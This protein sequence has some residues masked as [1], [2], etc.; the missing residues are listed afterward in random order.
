V[1]T[2]PGPVPC[3]QGALVNGVL[4]PIA[5]PL[6]NP[7]LNFG[8]AF[9]SFDTR[10]SRTFHFKEPH[11]LE[12][13]AEVFNLFN[14]TNI[15]GTTNRNY[16]GVNNVLTSSDFNPRARNSGEVLRLG[17]AEGFPVRT[18]LFLLIGLFGQQRARILTTGGG[19]DW[20]LSPVAFPTRQNRVA[21]AFHVC[22]RICR[23]LNSRSSGPSTVVAVPPSLA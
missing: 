10:V 1:A 23:S 17:R 2:P 15:R 20:F 4:T 14:V 9:N 22:L 8:H 18:P 3:N 11:S 16:S 21:C 19:R 7:K 13:I 12:A 5:L 6:V